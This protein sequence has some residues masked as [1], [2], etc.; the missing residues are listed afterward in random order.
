MA[1]LIRGRVRT[2]QACEFARID[3][4][5]F[6][7]MVH[8]RHYRCAPETRPGSARLFDIDQTIALKIYG[9]LLSM[10]VVPDRAGQIA[11]SAYKFFAGQKKVE[12]V[13]YRCDD[14]G[15]WIMDKENSNS[16]MKKP[17][18]L[19]VVFDI[20]E[21]REQCRDIFDQGFYLGEGD[22]NAAP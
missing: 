12:R 6:N 10:S 19:Q 7:E 1:V 2:K 8:A 5:R 14:S 21:L 22:D 20:S 18:S 11:C 3:P 9:D 16:R 17:R 15:K 4:A 13:V